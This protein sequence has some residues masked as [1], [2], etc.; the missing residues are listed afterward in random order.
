MDEIKDLESS[1]INILK[2]AL[3]YEIQFRNAMVSNSL[4]YYDAN[5]TQDIISTDF[6]WR[7]EFG[8]LLSVPERIGLSTPCKLSEFMDKWCKTMVPDY[9]LKKMPFLSDFRKFLLDLFE[10]GKRDF[11]VDYWMETPEGHKMYVTHITLLTQNENGDVC[12]LCIVKDRTHG[13]SVQEESHQKIIEAYAYVDPLTKGYNYIKFKEKLNRQTD[14]GMIVSM[15]MKSF[16]VINSICGIQKGDMVIK[17]IWDCIMEILDVKRNE[18]AAHINADQYIIFLPT[19]DESKLQEKLQMVTLALNQISNEMEIPQLMPYFGLSFWNPGKKIE[20]AYSEAIA[21]KNKIKD[22]QTINFAFFEYEDTHRIVQEKK[23]VD[24]FDDALAHK[25]FK[26]W[27]QPKY[28]PITRTMVGAEALVRWQH[29]DGKMIPPGTF[30]PLFERTG[31]IRRLDE[32]IFINVCEQQKKWQSQGKSIVPVSVNLSRASL[33]YKKVVNQ[34]KRLTEKIGIDTEYVPIEITESAAINNIDIKAI[35]DD[36]YA[37]GFSLHMDDFGSGY[38]SLASL[39]IMHFDTLKLDKSLI[40]YIGNFGGERLIEHTISL[41]KE[42]GIRV[43][44]EGVESEDQ[45]S[46]LNHIG[47]DSIQGYYFSKPLPMEEFSKLLTTDQ[48]ALPETD[49]FTSK[50]INELKQIFIKA[51]VFSRMVNLTQNTY[52]STSSE[53]DWRKNTHITSSVFDESVKE[54]AEKFIPPEYKDSYLN[55]MNRDNILQSFHGEEIIRII[56]YKR[57][58]DGKLVTL[59]LTTNIFKAENSDDIM[60]YCFSSLLED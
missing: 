54:L 21:A 44:A 17:A 49:N 29:P 11:S 3:Y 34:Y 18:I 45:V 15:D 40:D 43:T 6:F 22:S 30:I 57:Y 50:H 51:P 5:I 53:K 56:K 35:A 16:K 26:V 19:C 39:N 9:S 8:Q 20:L 7:D 55:F 48:V 2:R 12:A 36:F 28:S 58:I 52:T 25:E 32:Y 38:S 24:A 37:A 27:Y 23:L 31:L 60:M 59:R 4:S 47:C 13:V 1:Q 33:Y 10:S 14:S 41:A 46:F 42:L